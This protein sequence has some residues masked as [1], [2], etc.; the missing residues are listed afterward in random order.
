MGA[1]HYLPNPSHFTL[2]SLCKLTPSTLGLILPPSYTASESLE[3]R[4]GAQLFV[5]MLLQIFKISY[6]GYIYPLKI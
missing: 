2:E 3:H 5:T 1:R 6:G 4:F